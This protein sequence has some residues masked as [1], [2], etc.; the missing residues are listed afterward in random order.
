[1]LLP[2]VHDPQFRPDIPSNENE[3]TGVV[4]LRTVSGFLPPHHPTTLLLLLKHHPHPPLERLKA[5]LR[6]LSLLLLL[7]INPD[8]SSNHAAADREDWVNASALALAM[9]HF[10]FSSADVP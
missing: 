8:P 4:E 1:M 10:L 2:P 9:N 6:T 5:L 3:L 7:T